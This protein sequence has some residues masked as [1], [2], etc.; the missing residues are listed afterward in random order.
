MCFEAVALMGLYQLR[1]G[2]GHS[3]RIAELS[4]RL[5]TFNGGDLL[6][7]I[8]PSVAHDSLSAARSSSARP[9]SQPPEL[10]PV[11]FFRRDEPSQVG[12]MG[13]FLLLLFRDGPLPSPP[14][15]ATAACGY[16]ARRSVSRMTGDNSLSSLN[17]LRSSVVGGFPEEPLEVQPYVGWQDD[18]C[19][20]FTSPRDRERVRRG[21][22]RM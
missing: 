1:S 2:L 3:R 14:V 20:G 8:Q 18:D 15:E 12:L 6:S 7:A 5:L 16:I 10:F 19:D 9:P 22:H 4:Q 13:T 11:T 17:Y 21:A